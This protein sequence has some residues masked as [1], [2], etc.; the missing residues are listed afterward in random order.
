M[1]EA[2]RATFLARGLPED[3]LHYDSFEFAHLT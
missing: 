1:I 2:I 3:R